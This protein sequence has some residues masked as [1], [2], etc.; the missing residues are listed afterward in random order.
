MPLAIWKGRVV[1][2]D[3]VNALPGEGN[4]FEISV[5]VAAC[6]LLFGEGNFEGRGRRR[7][8]GLALAASGNNR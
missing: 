6:R 4:L 7:S 2:R 3:H 8:D 1:V 5:E